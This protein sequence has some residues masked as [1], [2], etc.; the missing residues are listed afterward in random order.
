M[1]KIFISFVSLLV[2]IIAVLFSLRI[3][4]HH[5][6]HLAFVEELTNNTSAM[7]KASLVRKSDAIIVRVS[8]GKEFRLDGFLANKENYFINFWFVACGGCVYEMPGLEAFYKKYNNQID[9]AFISN[10]SV[11]DVKKFIAKRKFDI[12]FYVFKKGR[13]P[14]FLHVFPTSYYVAQRKDIFFYENMG[15]FDK[16]PFYDFM[17]STLK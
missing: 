12:P 5:K 7:H 17:D 14:D 3:Y 1:K 16:R 13:F 15:Y 6:R 8:D 10:D 2:L 4:N 11:K 9:F